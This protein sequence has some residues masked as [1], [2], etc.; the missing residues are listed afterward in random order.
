MNKFSILLFT[1]SVLKLHAQSN[2]SFN[3]TVYSGSAGVQ[4]NT[5]GGENAFP[6]FAGER[7]T[8]I[9]A[10][11]YNVFCPI[12]SNNTVFGADACHFNYL[13]SY[14]TALGYGSLYANE[15]ASNNTAIGYYALLSFRSRNNA[16]N[17]TAVGS[18]CLEQDSLGT[19]NTAVGSYALKGNKLGNYNCALGVS[20]LQN[21]IYNDNNTAIGYQAMYSNNGA[22]NCAIGFQSMMSNGIGSDNIAVGYFSLLS[23][24]TGSSNI[25]IGV[26]ALKNSG[27]GYFNTAVGT[28]AGLSNK[29]GSNNVFIGF[30]AGA[31]ETSGNRLYISSGASN[32]ILYGDFV[33]G[34]LLVGSPNPVGY[35]FKGNRKLNVIG[36]ILTDSIRI[37][38][39]NKWADYV[40][41]D[42][43]QLKSIDELENF[44]K[45]NKHLPNIPSADN[46]LCEGVNIAEMDAKLLEKVEELS[47]YIIELNNEHKN[48]L[49]KINEKNSQLILK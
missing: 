16:T 17:N 24:V 32:T 9:G 31:N 38:S 13:G 42:D 12:G 26:N 30:E 7:N 35:Q 14:N 15:Y 4:Y 37:A 21:S 29:S 46:V 18:N 48:L 10:N 5:R 49:Q 41:S 25:A 23:N 27:Y 34:Q 39:V 47:L 44:I 1:F 22:R 45:Q 11:A 3:S 43:Y 2:Y 8:V 28:N 19:D 36:G 20:A 33:T 40:F 6:C